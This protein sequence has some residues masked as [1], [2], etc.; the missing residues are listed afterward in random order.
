MFPLVVHSTFS[1]RWT[2]SKISCILVGF[3]TYFSSSSSLYLMTFV[4]FQRYYILLRPLCIRKD[5]N[6]KMIKIVIIC[7]LLGLFW[8]AAPLFGWSHYSLEPGYISCSIEWKDNN[9]NVFSYNVSVFLFLFILPF[10]III[11]TNLKA[12]LIVIKFRLK[13]FVLK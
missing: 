13:Y 9:L 4:S 3:V 12:I 2:S 5:K 11:I 8:S 6:K 7:C 1:K 10:G